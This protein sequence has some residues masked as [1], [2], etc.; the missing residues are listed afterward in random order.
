MKIFSYKQHNKWIEEF[1]ED[2]IIPFVSSPHLR[3]KLKQQAVK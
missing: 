1:F 2:F 3:S